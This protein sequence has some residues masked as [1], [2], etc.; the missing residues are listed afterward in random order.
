MNKISV[1]MPLALKLLTS[2]KIQ[3]HLPE[4]LPNQQS[5]RKKLIPKKITLGIWLISIV[6]FMNCASPSNNTTDFSEMYLLQDMKAFSVSNPPE[7]NQFRLWYFEHYLNTIPNINIYTGVFVSEGN[8]LAAH[9]IEGENTEKGTLI[10]IHGYN[11]TVLNGH[12]QYFAQHFIPLGYRV[13]LLN[14]PGHG[15]S[16]GVRGDVRDFADYGSMIKDFLDITKNQL[17]ENIVLIGHSTGAIAIY[18]SYIQYPDVMKYIDAAVLISPFKDIKFG[19]LYE[20]GSVFVPSVSTK[21][22]QILRLR[23]VPSVWI[24][25]EKAWSKKIKTYPIL[26]TK[27]MLLIFGENDTV[28]TKN[29]SI[30][31]YNKQ[32][33]NK[34]M[35]IYPNQNHAFTNDGY[36][37]FREETILWIAQKLEEPISN[38][39]ES[40]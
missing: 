25:K 37:V 22:K 14:L 32:I 36:N 39:Q 29:E 38:E 34:K 17:G 40:R 15:F 23:T 2:K 27:E 4:Y 21:Y 19:T 16:G 8:I 30:Q 33:T 3:G 26:D 6:F 31:F 11:G 24:Q 13:I 28:I 35:R 1:S 20:V 9:M 7:N 10:M 12:F 18:E 5:K